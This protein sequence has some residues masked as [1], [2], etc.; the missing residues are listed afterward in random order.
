[1]MYVKLHDS[2]NFS[3]EKIQAECA[4]ERFNQKYQSQ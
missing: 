1:L 4:S 2:C 3:F